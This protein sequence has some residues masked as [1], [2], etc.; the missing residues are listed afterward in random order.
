MIEIWQVGNT[1]VRNP[2]R[3]HEA[4]RLYAESNLVG[5]IRGV[6]GAVAFTNYLCERGVLNNA[7]GKDP[8]GSYGRKWRL[9]FNKNGFTY[10]YVGKDGLSQA[11]VG[12]IDGITPFGKAFLEADTV[13]AVQEFFL[14]ASAMHMEPLPG[15]GAFS[16]LRWTRRP[17]SR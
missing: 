14:R 11:D 10:G 15:G 2:M 8:T 7:P 4:F 9:V 3:I 16:P 6:A 5:K 13:P 17:R 12:A 1:G